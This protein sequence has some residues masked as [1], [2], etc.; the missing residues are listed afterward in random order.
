MN[1]GFLFGN[2]HTHTH[3]QLTFDLQRRFGHPLLH[4]F[5]YLLDLI[6][7]V[8]HHLLQNAGLLQPTPEG[9]RVLWWIPTLLLDNPQI[10]SRADTH[11]RDISAFG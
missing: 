9:D 10:S 2:V 7:E 5:Q 3:T 8:L 6:L 4:A 1:K 11:A